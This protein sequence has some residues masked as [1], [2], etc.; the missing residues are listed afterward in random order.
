MSVPREKDLRIVV[1]G[2]GLRLGLWAALSVLEAAESL[3]NVWRWRVGKTGSGVPER[4]G[5]DAAARL[6]VV[7]LLAVPPVGRARPRWAVARLGAPRVGVGV[8]GAERGLRLALLVLSLGLVE[9]REAPEEEPILPADSCWRSIGPLRSVRLSLVRLAMAWLA[10]NSCGSLK[11]ISAHPPNE[12]V[13]G[14]YTQY[15]RATHSGSFS[16]HTKCRLATIGFCL[17][18][19]RDELMLMS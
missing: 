12:C 17:F 9:E 4:S 5:V 13:G 18:D 2:R 10:R 3:E 15:R 14:C 19:G 11:A 8:R 7:L 16:L 6:R 1:E